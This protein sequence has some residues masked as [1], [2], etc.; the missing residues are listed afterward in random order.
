[1]AEQE[2]GTRDHWHELAE[3]LGLPPETEQPAAPRPAKPAGEPAPAVSPARSEAH[4]VT[5]PP[6]QEVGP[7]DEDLT[8]PKGPP[9][10]V[11]TAEAVRAAPREP[12][13][14]FRPGRDVHPE[15]EEPAAEPFAPQPARAF[16][17]IAEE[18]TSPPR[19][20]GRRGA[21]PRE[22][23]RPG[24]DRVPE[25][26][27]RDEEAGPNESEAAGEGPE[28]ERGGQAGRRRRRGRGR[29][30]RLDVP[31][32]VPADLPEEPAEEPARQPEAEE[33]E[34]VDTL[35]DWDVP[36]W[37]ELIASLYRPDR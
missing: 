13:P 9:T 20:R 1:M 26:D 37:N 7:I 36:S 30:R 34:P 2:S 29:G 5:L 32:T 6:P 31:E 35:S 11:E 16:G 27:R 24:F 25:S 23:A 22:D 3:M 17:E 33:P 14:A 8:F 10:R 18:G 12:E 21:R 4:R 28:A 15:P 19:R